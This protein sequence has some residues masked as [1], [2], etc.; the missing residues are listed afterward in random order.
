MDSNRRYLL[1]EKVIDENSHYK[2]F[3]FVSDLSIKPGQFIMLSDLVNG[4]KPFS[5]SDYGNGT[6]S[7][8]VKKI[9]VFTEKLFNKKEGEPLII[10]GAYGRA[11][12]IDKLSPEAN[13]IIVGGGC[14][15]APLRFLVKELSK[16]TSNINVINSSKTKDELLFIGEIEGIASNLIYTTD[17]GSFGEK[18]NAVE[19]F[20]EIFHEDKYD[21]LYV[22]G[23]EIMQK[24]ILDSIIEKNIEAEFLIE[25]YMKCAV[26]IC[27]QCTIDPTGIRVCVEGAVFNKNI[28]KTCTEFGYYKRDKAGNR[29]YI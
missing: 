11:F 24:K 5:I 20:E 12:S 9:G 13:I 14:G 3:S 22:S 18:A 16:K 1:I 19:I 10:R 26:G 7:V 28:L 17:D 4:E 6:F 25:R 15:F 8:T 2:T 29:I 27:G 21:M 23:P